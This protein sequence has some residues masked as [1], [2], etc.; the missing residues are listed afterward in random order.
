MTNQINYHLKSVI[1]SVLVDC[2]RREMSQKGCKYI[3]KYCVELLNLISQN[4][5]DILL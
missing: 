4:L 3:Y 1:N 2:T 5:N